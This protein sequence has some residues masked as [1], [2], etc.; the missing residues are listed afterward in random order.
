MMRVRVKGCG[1]NRTDSIS[2]ANEVVKGELTWK[3]KA[4]RPNQPILQ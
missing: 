1:P 3:I 4:N 2:M